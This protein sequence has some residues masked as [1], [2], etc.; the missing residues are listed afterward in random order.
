MDLS[1]YKGRDPRDLPIYTIVAAGH[2]LGLHPGTLGTWLRGRVYHTTNGSRRAPNVIRPAKSTPL[3]LSF[4]NLVE[5]QVLA[6]IRR[7]HGVSLQRVRKALKFVETELS[8]TR[9]LINEEFATD[10]VNL[11]IEKFGLLIN[12]SDGQLAMRELLDAA[13]RRVERDPRGLAVRLFP[14][15]NDPREESRSIEIDPLRAF[16]RPVVAGTTV[17]TK[18]LGERFLAGD[19]FLHLSKEYRLDS[20]VVEQAVRWELRGQGEASA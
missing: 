17:P 8:L 10:G 4:W 11:F 12:V 7:Q 3:M 20:E 5:A 18:I 16:G 2:H 1:I 15:A 14:W 6:S 9:P 19:S 13:L